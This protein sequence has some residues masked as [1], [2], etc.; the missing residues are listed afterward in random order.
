MK[1][2][3]NRLRLARQDYL[4]STVF[5]VVSVEQRTQRNNK[6]RAKERMVR[7]KDLTN[8]DELFW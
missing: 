1:A 7:S 3:S 5:V 6:E 8:Q 2:Y 4:D